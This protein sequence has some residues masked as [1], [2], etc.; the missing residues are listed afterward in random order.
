MAMQF[1]KAAAKAGLPAANKAAPQEIA[2]QP[3]PQGVVSWMKTGKAAVDAIKEEEAKAQLRA[4][5]SKLLRRFWLK[6]GDEARITFLDGSLDKDGNL[7]PDH[8]M[9]EHN[10][11]LN[12]EWTQIM[13]TRGLDDSGPCP[14][15]ES[16][17]DGN[18]PYFAA[19]WTIINHTPYVIQNGPNKG[20]TLV[21][22]KALY[23]AKTETIGQ[24]TKI[25]M[26]RG[27]LAG[28]T[29]DVSRTGEMSARCGNQLDVQEQWKDWNAFRQKYDLK[30]E[31]ITPANYEA[32]IKYRDRATLIALGI[33]KAIG[34]VGT[35]KAP[36][37]LKSEL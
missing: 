3:A 22:R 8:R 23:I 18:V 1:A 11:Y 32:E 20:K 28:L 15:C 7:S 5:E 36:S 21:N 17:M 34:G 2:Q 27:G 9:H 29:I 24:L 13:C 25:A 6:N 33:G 16:T 12:G 35:E 14:V 30:P 37:N 10:V 4:E 26:K 31:D 19:F